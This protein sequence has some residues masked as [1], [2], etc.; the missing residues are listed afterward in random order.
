MDF[1]TVIDQ[2][3]QKV[4]LPFP[5]KR[6]ISLVPSQTELLSDLGLRQEVIGITKFCVHP[7][8]WFKSKQKIGGTKQLDE[9]AIETLNP[10]LIIGN[11]EENERESIERLKSKFP[12]W[13]SDIYTLEDAVKMISL[14]GDVTDR[15][16]RAAEII[17]AIK[18][19]FDIL[20]RFDGVKV[21]YLIWKNPWMAAGRNTFID[22]MLM[23]LGFI[24][25]LGDRGRYPVIEEKEMVTIN[26]DVVMM[27]S[28]PFPFGDRHIGEVKKLL[29]HSKP[30]LVDGEMFSWYGSR[31]LKAPKYFQALK[32]AY[33]HG[34]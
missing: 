18:A 30:L 31:L 27:S 34:F 21:L 11:K 22:H 29:P 6:I 20:P 10:D 16:I 8:D 24:N 25:A 13:M 1:R 26:P 19:G 7:S 33:P 2:M 5:P 4:E 15:Q 28:E 9:V 12:V 17:N 14:V 3:N 23:R 32:D